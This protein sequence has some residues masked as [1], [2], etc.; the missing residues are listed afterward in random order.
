MT[1]LNTLVDPD[2]AGHLVFANDIDDAGTITASGSTRLPGWLPE[3]LPVD[4]ALP[5]R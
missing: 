4:V 2:C 5:R 1:D 3:R